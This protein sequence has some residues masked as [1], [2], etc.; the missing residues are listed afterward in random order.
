MLIQVTVVQSLN[1]SNCPKV[2]PQSLNHKLTTTDPRAK[3]IYPVN[4]TP[5]ANKQAKWQSVWGSLS[6]AEFEARSSYQVKSKKW[7][8]LDID[9]KICDRIVLFAFLF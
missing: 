6:S 7:V 3:L 5:L 9:Y 2:P 8:F 4:P 1:F